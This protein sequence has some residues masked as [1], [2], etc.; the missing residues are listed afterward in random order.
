MRTN[1]ITWI[2]LL[3][4]TG[5]SVLLAQASVGRSALAAGILAVA[6]AKFLAVGFQFMEIRK[7]HAV[8]SLL[9]GGFAVTFAALVFL[10]H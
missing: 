10:L 1:T 7:A 3:A 2:T 6:C 8:W 5:V 9:L 4:L